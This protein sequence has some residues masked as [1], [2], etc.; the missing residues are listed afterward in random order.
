MLAPSN[1]YRLLINKLDKFIRKYYV[2][3]LIRGALY[4]IAI[5]AISF[6]AVSLLEHYFYFSKE[7]RK[8]LFYGFIAVSVLTFIIAVLVPLLKIFRLGKVISHEKASEIIG[9]HFSNV[10]D[11][12]LNILQL[13]EQTSTSSSADLINASINQKIENLR[14]VPFTRA[15]DLD[16]NKRYLKYAIPPLLILFT[17]LVAAPNMITDPTDRLINNDQD[18]ER[19]AP[20]L[21]TLKTEDLEIIQY[22][23]ILLEVDVDGEALPRDTYIHYNNFSY[24]LDKKSPSEFNFKMNNLQKDVTFYFE[25]DG[26]RSL[27]YKLNVIPKPAIV[28]FDAKINY[29][30]YTGRKDEVLR[31]TGDMVL[32]YGTQVTWNFEAL[33]AEV[34]DIE[35]KKEKKQA[36]R[37]SADLFNF[38]KRIYTDDAYTVYVSNEKIQKAD[39]ISYGISVI[40]D[41]F[42]NISVEEIVDSANAQI[43]YFLGEASDDYGINSLNF[44]Y[45]IEGGAYQTEPLEST[46]L[47]T[48]IKYQ[49]SFDAEALGLKPGESMAYHFEVWDNDGIKGSKFTKTQEMTYELPSMR[50]LQEEV[51]DNKEEFKEDLKETLKDAKELK[52]E[53]KELKERVLQKKEMSWEDREAAKELLEKHKN[54]ESQLQQMQQDF[55]ENLQQEQ[56]FKEFSQDI[57]EK[58]EKLQELMEELLTEEMKEMMEKLEELMEEMSNEEMME[59]LEEMELSDEE[60]EQE[61]DKMLELMKQLEFEQKMEETIEALEELAEDQ[62]E[63]SEDTQ[64]NESGNLDKEEK[65]QEKLNERFEDVM[66]DLEKLDEMGEE[67]QKPADM[68]EFQE[69][70]EDVKE[71]QEKASEELEKNSSKGAGPK[72]KSAAQKMKEMAAGMSAMKQQMQQEQQEEDM[73]AIRQLLENLI[74]LSLDQ[75]LLMDDIAVASINTPK[76]VELV[77]VQHKLKDDARM[78]EDS[79]IALSKRVFQIESFVNKELRQINMNLRESLSNLEERKVAPANSNQQY[80]MTS[81]NNLALMFDEAMQQMQ[82]AM[83]S[84]QP[85]D[86]NCNKPGGSGSPG[87]SG[88]LGD[89]QKQLNDQITQMKEGMGKKPGKGGKGGK[90]GKGGMSKEFA[91]MA[92]K[93]AAIRDAMQKMAKDKEGKGGG[94]ELEELM[95]EMDK[96]EAELVNKKLTNEMLKRQQEIL[97]RLLKAEKAEQQRELDEKRQAETAQEKTKTIPPEI[98]EYLKK[99]EAEV[100]LYKTVPPSLRPYYK[101]LVEKYFKAISF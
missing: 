78:V 26:F 81:L 98:E 59:E 64:D 45:K 91:K 87:K 39:S 48:A 79:I 51:D 95:E 35:F 65:E 47:K 90:D 44:K 100:E 74:R 73:K 32:P 3:K 27:D 38:S 8:S 34:V 82:Q 49:H 66:E 40:P 55:Q 97:T 29:P 4:T 2:N 94:G 28:G 72:Q 33:N 5:V 25:A 17:L 6:L 52:E 24:K 37:K 46:G 11:K 1:N 41:L 70:G 42:P 16:K 85:G 62:E 99:R 60:L 7:V 56:E 50:E 84:G 88:K 20:F 9:T 76:Y 13:K 30:A 10:Q 92:Q 14:P 96:T 77:Q 67:L 93:Q 15:I 68:D 71:D 23:D 69:E 12:L 89:L 18:F 19:P 83:E 43:R 58:N 57:Q 54:M 36:E 63:L 80:V 86:G 101:S 53:V 22:E 61:L 21:F 31:N 75:E